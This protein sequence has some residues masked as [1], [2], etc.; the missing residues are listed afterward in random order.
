MI[1]PA[2]IAA[3]LSLALTAGCGG[4][5]AATAGDGTA[6]TTGP[7]G[8]DQVP[9]PATDVDGTG[10]TDRS[11][12][13]TAPTG[14]EPDA[15]GSTAPGGTEPDTG[16]TNGEEVGEMTIHYTVEGGFTGQTRKL[17]IGEDGS[18][19]I[20]RNG[21]V[22]TGRL[23][24]SRRTA[25]LDALDGSGLFVRDRE[26]RQPAGADLQRYEIRYRGHTVVVWDT[27]IPPELGEAL[28][29]LDEVLNPQ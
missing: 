21:A 9:V 23:D 29:L 7:V 15:T 27:T 18:V 13:T 5:G 19:K 11:G 4:G 6:M 26:D 24:A 10:P 28:T 8:S 20:D 22:T 3:A 16:I 2:L 12:A 25:V 14:T 17:T 1:R